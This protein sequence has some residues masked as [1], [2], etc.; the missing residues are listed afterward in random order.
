[1]LLAMAGSKWEIGWF[2]INFWTQASINIQLETSDQGLLIVVMRK[3]GG[4]V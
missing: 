4:F 3:S 1:M 2:G